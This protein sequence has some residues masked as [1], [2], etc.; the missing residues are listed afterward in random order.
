MPIEKRIKLCIIIERLHEYRNCG[1][2]LGIEDRTR[3]R[4]KIIYNGSDKKC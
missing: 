4:G 2:K 3:F 1:E